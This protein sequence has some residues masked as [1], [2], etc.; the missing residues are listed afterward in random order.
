MKNLL[1]ARHRRS[2]SERSVAL[3]S[4]EAT[5]TSYSSRAPV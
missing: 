5:G 2:Q 1:A 3:A 4:R